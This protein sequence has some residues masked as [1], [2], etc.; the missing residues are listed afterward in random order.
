MTIETKKLKNGFEIPAFGIGTW[1]MG[2]SFQR[3]DMEDGREIQ[4]IA[5]AIDLGVTCLDTAELYGAGHAEELLGKA[6][7]GRDRSKLF[8]ISKVLPAGKKYDDFLAACRMSLKRVGTDYFDLYLIHHVPDDMKEAMRAMNTLAAQGL[9]RNIG[10]SNFGVELLEEAR[11]LAEHPIVYDQVHYNLEFR[12]PERAGLLAYCQKNDIF[13]AAWRPVQKGAL[14]SNTPAIVRELCEKYGK[15]P[16]QIALNWLISQKNVVTLAKSSHVEHLKENLGAVG[17]QM[18]EKD[19]ER[20]R[21]E[22][23][24]QKDESDSVPLGKPI[25][26]VHR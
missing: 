9:I 6:I 15:T 14:A 2:G 23:P 17:W 8:I 11:A 3:S 18:E 16:V 5:A 21:R 25:G 7:E 13:L 26:S 12:E 24:D 20:L 4:A 19:I 22:Y 1:G 10:V